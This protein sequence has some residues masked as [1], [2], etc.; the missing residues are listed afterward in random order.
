[1]SSFL[2]V[3][4]QQEQEISA[5]RQQLAADEPMPWPTVVDLLQ[6]VLDIVQDIRSCS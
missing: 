5:V 6:D 3:G 4:E 2:P 1:M